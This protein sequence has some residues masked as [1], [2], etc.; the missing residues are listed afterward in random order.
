M[1]LVSG[2]ELVVATSGAGLCGTFPT[3]NA[4]TTETLDQWLGEMGERLAGKPFGANLIVHKSNPRV[5]EDLALLVKHKVPLVITSLG[6][7]PDVAAAVHSYGG[8]VL[9]DVISI[10]H[11]QKAIGAGADGLVAVCAGAGGHA[12]TIS[13]FAL[14]AEIRAFFDGPL[15][16]SGALTQGR[17]IAAARVMGADFGY[18]GS[19]FIAADESM[20]PDAQKQMMTQAHAAD[21]VLT[22]KVT[23]V[24][25]NFMRQSLEA[26]TLP[27][28]HGEM[29]LTDEAKAWKTIWSAG[30]GVGATLAIRPAADICAE[31][32]TQ[33]HEALKGIAT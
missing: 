19:H 14:T 7:V 29:A 25:A 30:H 6:A 10:R 27:D 32:I 21:I 18:I 22:D 9:H 15:A 26:A 33:Y 8:M 24:A 2:V 12:G 23:G 1:F 13:P 31:L 28:G 11:A 3:L 16:L 20:A 17:H 5:A 4:R